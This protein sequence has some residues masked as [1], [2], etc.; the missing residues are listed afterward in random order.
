M[1]EE[2]RGKGEKGGREGT[3]EGKEEAKEKKGKKRKGKEKEI[4]E[5]GYCRV[6]GEIN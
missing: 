3:K 4:V 1:E 6:H 2:R 5:K